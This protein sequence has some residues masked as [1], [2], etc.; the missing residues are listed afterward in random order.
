MQGRGGVRGEAETKEPR[1]LKHSQAQCSSVVRTGLLASLP[2]SWA[3]W[4]PQ[5]QI[6]SKYRSVLGHFLSVSSWG[7]YLIGLS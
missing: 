4:T 5:L 7:E 2:L 3:M 6:I 1:Q